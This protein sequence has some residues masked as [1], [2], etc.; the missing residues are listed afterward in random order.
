ML[1]ADAGPAM[2][3]AVEPDLVVSAFSAD[4]DCV[5]LLKFPR[6]IGAAI[7]A[8]ENL[9]PGR[10][11]I[12]LSSYR[13]EE[14]MASDLKPGANYRAWTNFQ[15]FVAEFLAD[16]AQRLAALHAAMPDWAWQRCKD[17]TAAAVKA[18]P[19]KFRDGRPLRSATPAK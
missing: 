6:E 14:Q 15:P 8:E 19:V 2:V 11:L 3:V 12:A 17:L 9:K 16:D 10:R 1:F 18:R 5:V 4:I 7:V 13:D